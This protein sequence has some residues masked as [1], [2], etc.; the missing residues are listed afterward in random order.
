MRLLAAMDCARTAG[1]VAHIASMPRT[2]ANQ[3]AQAP[4]ND[5]GPSAARGFPTTESRV[6]RYKCIMDDGAPEGFLNRHHGTPRNPPLTRI[7]GARRIFQPVAI[8]F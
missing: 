6:K 3:V 5:R 4:A 7:A 1:D 8:F 2:A